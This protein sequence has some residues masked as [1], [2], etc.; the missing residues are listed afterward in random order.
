MVRVFS[1]VRAQS[2]RKLARHPEFRPVTVL[3]KRIRGD[4]DVERQA[5]EQSDFLS[6]RDAAGRFAD[7][8]ATRHTYISGLVAGGKASVKTL[9]ELA[10]HSTPVLTIGRYSYVRLHD[11]TA[12]LEAL[13]DL[14]PE[15]TDLQPPATTTGT[16]V[17]QCGSKCGSSRAAKWRTEAAKRG[18]TDP[19]KESQN[20]RPNVLQM[21]TLGERRRHAAEVVRGRIELPTHGFSVCEQTPENTGKTRV[22]ENAGSA[23]GSAPDE[24]RTVPSDLQAIID[25][26]ESLPDAIRAGIVVMVRA[27]G[28]RG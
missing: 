22:S 10:R 3:T 2:H 25:A 16:D 9:Q 28:S 14:T 5:R 1:T 4:S 26:W 12:A 24:K 18:G 21:N 7:F 20:A 17:V 8:Y 6:F 19:S 13:P 15:K 11:L 27:A 23:T